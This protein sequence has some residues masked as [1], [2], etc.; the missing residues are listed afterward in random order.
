MDIRDESATFRLRTVRAYEPNRDLIDYVENV[1]QPN[2]TPATISKYDYASDALGRRTNVDYTG[3]AFGSPTPPI[4]QPFGYND[5][6]ELTSSSRGA[7]SWG[8][9]YDPIG[10]R[11]TY[12][13]EGPVTTTYTSN[14]LNQYERWDRPGS[15][16]VLARQRYTYDEDGNLAQTWVA[17]DMNCDG[18]V[19]AADINLFQMAIIMGKTWWETTYP[20][21]PY[22]NGDGLV[23]FGDINPF[24]SLMAAGNA[25]A[26]QTFAWDA[27]NRLIEVRPTTPTDG[28]WKVVFGYDQ[29][30]RRVD[31]R[32]Y[33]W[34]GPGPDDWA[35]TP[36]ERRKFVWSGW[37]MFSELDEVFGQDAVLRKYA[38]G[39]GRRVAELPGF[40]RAARPGDR[41][42]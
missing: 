18:L 11:Q 5:R 15:P 20:N 32:V 14:E 12:T 35:A 1:W 31:K 6:N 3:V 29:Q 19:N 24:S 7:A 8:Y 21:C 10:N 38:W 13:T 33:D 16:G 41:H 34:V 39:L 28:D 25:A 9:L 27:E 23:D 4:G 2:G 30:G 42:R 17:G 26:D 22:L 37:L 36:A 40:E